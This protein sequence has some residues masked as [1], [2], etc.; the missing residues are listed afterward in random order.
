LIYTHGKYFGHTTE[1]I[2]DLIQLVISDSSCI[3][4]GENYGDGIEI[5]Y[6]EEIDWEKINSDNSLTG[7]IDTIQSALIKLEKNIAKL[8]NETK[9]L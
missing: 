2:K 5:P 9:S 8:A 7:N 1:E 4:I 6:P 3:V